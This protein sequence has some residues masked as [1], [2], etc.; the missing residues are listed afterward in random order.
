LSNI[1]RQKDSEVTECLDCR[2]EDWHNLWFTF[3]TRF[4][5]LNASGSR[6]HWHLVFRDG[7]ASLAVHEDVDYI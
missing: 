3:L 2:Q 6:R 5:G 4:T 1:F 7:R